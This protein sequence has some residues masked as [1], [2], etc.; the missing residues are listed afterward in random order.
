MLGEMYIAY[1]TLFLK[2]RTVLYVSKNVFVYD[3]YKKT[4]GLKKWKQ[5]IITIGS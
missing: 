4:N 1:E 5:S 3:F 2:R